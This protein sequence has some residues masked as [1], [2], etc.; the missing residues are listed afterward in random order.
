MKKYV[1]TTESEN[2]TMNL[3]RKVGAF[4]KPGD[5]IAMTGD[6]GAGKTHFTMGV[7]ETLGITEYVSSPTFTI[8][9]EYTKGKMPLY[10]MDAYRLGDPDELME[11]GFEE[12]LSGGGVIIIE[13]ADI[14]EDVLPPDTIW[15]EIQRMDM[16]GLN[17]RNI[18][19]KVP[20][21][22]DRFADF[23]N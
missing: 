20:E 10:H 12:Y 23:G 19:L 18:I 14:V 9:N 1:F 21:G 22:D 4:L 7:A 8:V 17:T 15:V 11:I 13:W 16:V 6:L 3:G 2:E 5:V